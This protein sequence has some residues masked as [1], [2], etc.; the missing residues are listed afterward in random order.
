MNKIIK[1]LIKNNKFLLINNYKNIK[2]NEKRRNYGIDLYKIIAT[3]NIVIL[4]INKHSKLINLS[5]NSSQFKIIWSLEILTYWGVNGFGLISGF[6]GYKRYKFSNLMY[7]WTEVF[8]YSIFISIILFLTKEISQIQL[9][10]SLFPLL[11]KR[12][13]Y[14]NAYFSMY[15]IL[16]F[17]NEGIKN[18]KKIILKNIVIFLIL[19]FSFYHVVAKLIKKPEYSFLY[20]GYSSTWLTFLY[21]IGSYISK[22]IIDNEDKKFLTYIFWLF[23]YLLSSFFTLGIYF[24]TFNFKNIPNN[25]FLNYLSPTILFQA[26]SLLMIFSRLQIKNSIIINIICFLNKLNFSV[27]LIHGRLFQSRNSFC[28][29]F[30]IWV[31]NYKGNL[32]FL[33]IYVISLFVYFICIVIDYF[34]LSLFKL[35]NVRYFFE[36]IENKFFN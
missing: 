25:L 16:P 35:L 9:I 26:I 21:I 4:H 19:Y 17:I 5:R 1:P 33:R 8:F 27:I 20:D 31:K 36:I 6:V 13:W 22:Y 12:H 28:K 32:I 30:F 24:N 3:I 34:R 15:I 2:N 10:Y 7:I 11:I 29:M 14:V 18:L 23:I